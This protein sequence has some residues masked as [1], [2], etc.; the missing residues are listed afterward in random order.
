MSIPLH[1][2]LFSQNTF[3]PLIGKL[4][5]NF[6]IRL[7]YQFHC[8]VFPVT[9]H[10]APSNHSTSV[11]TGLCSYFCDSTCYRERQLSPHKTVD[12][13]KSPSR[14]GTVINLCILHALY[15]VW[16][17]DPMKGRKEKDMWTSSQTDKK[18]ATL[19]GSEAVS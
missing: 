3:S 11:L 12:R 13:T 17:A 15:G 5:P 6:K 7:K 2:L 4:L 14:T 8:K 16:H 18:H 10:V 9:H 1:T 19:S